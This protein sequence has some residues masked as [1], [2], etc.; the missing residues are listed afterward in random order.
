MPKVEYKQMEIL[1]ILKKSKSWV[2]AQDLFGKYTKEKDT[3]TI[4]EFYQ[5][6]RFLLN[7]GDIEVKRKDENDWFRAVVK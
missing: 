7:N 6:L 4:E 2:K 3:D 5:K 1:E